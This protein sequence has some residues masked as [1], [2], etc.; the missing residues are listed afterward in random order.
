MVLPSSAAH[1]TY[2]TMVTLSVFLQDARLSRFISEAE[3]HVSASPTLL[4]HGGLRFL[5]SQLGMGAQ[6]LELCSGSSSPD[7]SLISLLILEQSSWEG[8]S[9]QGATRCPSAFLPTHRVAC[10]I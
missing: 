6:L 2:H 1:T 4:T 7:P 5:T 10:R 9:L 8:C 3:F